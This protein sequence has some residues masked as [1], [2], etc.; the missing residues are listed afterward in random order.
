[1]KWLYVAGG[2]VAFLAG[3]AIVYGCHC[4]PETN[5]KPLA[6]KPYLPSD[7]VR[8]LV[9]LKGSD[10]PPS[11][12]RWQLSKEHEAQ[13]KKMKRCAYEWPSL[14]GKGPD[15]AALGDNW[16]ADPVVLGMLQ[17]NLKLTTYL[18]THLT[19]LQAAYRGQVGAVDI[20]W[21]NP[22]AP[23]V[24][25][26]VPDSSPQEG[27]NGVVPPGAGTHHGYN[28]A[29]IARWVGCKDNASC[30]I[31]VMTEP[32]LA[33]N[34][35]YYGTVGE[36]AAAVRALVDRKPQGERLVLNLSVGWEPNDS[37]EDKCDVVPVKV[38]GKDVRPAP[39][40]KGENVASQLKKELQRAVCNGA[41]VIAAA[42]N[43]PGYAPS[44]KG[45]MCPALWGT[46][47]APTSDDCAKLGVDKSDLQ[48]KMLLYPVGAVNDTYPISTTRQA[49]MPALAAPG[50]SGVALRDPAYSEALTGTS[51]SAA[52]LSGMAAAVWAYSPDKKAYEVMEILQS[53]AI[54]LNVDGGLLATA[55]LQPKKASLCKAF[56]K[57]C[58][59]SLSA[60]CPGVSLVACASSS[61]IVD[62]TV[63]AKEQAEL[64][65]YFHTVTWNKRRWTPTP[66]ARHAQPFDQYLYPQPNDPPCPT[67][68]FD[69]SD[70]TIYILVNR[71]FPPSLCPLAATT[72]KFFDSGG[73]L[74]TGGTF[75][76]VASNLYPGDAVQ[77]SDIRE[78]TSPVPAS[79]T[80]TWLQHDNTLVTQSISLV[81]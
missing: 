11:K 50:Y 29:N 70:D 14:L 38:D 1:M 66:A 32:A 63:I 9:E 73:N 12:G 15:Y 69:K 79:A 47:D 52:A 4:A 5:P 58:P 81:E 77:V 71:N 6:E 16:S 48:S 61:F 45:L 55:G 37:K 53:S 64:D 60:G 28:V 46:E 26:G 7:T 2:A 59:S 20:A 22:V 68:Q 78:P 72:L 67:C 30:P 17:S 57:M 31:H 76:N 19:S 10:C 36:L 33:Y 42:G 51:V 49:G 54:Q 35:G 74:I 13:F 80:L 39:V 18:K 25:I 34:G 75:N 41:V 40:G 56:E 8:V 21:P 23:K 43:D 44:L 62:T 27:P 65:D 3:G 24:V